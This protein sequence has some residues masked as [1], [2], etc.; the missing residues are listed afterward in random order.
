MY[1]RELTIEILCQIHWS[2]QIIIRKFKSI[3]SPEDFTGS[4][5]G[6][7]KLDAICMQLIAI[8]ESLKNLDKVT[9]KTLLRNYPQ[10]EW[11]KSERH[12]RYHLTPL[13]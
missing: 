5:S 7:D 3:D 10:I 2:T 8:G 1:D 4:D 9:N 11:K 12:E 6:M 13:F